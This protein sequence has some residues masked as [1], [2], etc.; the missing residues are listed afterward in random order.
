MLR[1]ICMQAARLRQDRDRLQ[2]EAEGRE[3]ELMQLQGQLVMLQRQIP[4][5]NCWL[6]PLP[7]PYA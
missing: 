7:D 2:E 1:V 4:D 3:A 6:A 5:D